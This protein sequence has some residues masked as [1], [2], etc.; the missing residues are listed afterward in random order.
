MDPAFDVRTDFTRMT[1][2]SRAYTPR[3]SVLTRQALSR[4]ELGYASTA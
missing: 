2:R 1:R 4:G 3:H